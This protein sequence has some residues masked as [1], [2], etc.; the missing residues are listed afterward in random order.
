MFRVDPTCKSTSIVS[1]I[2]GSVEEDYP[3]LEIT[4]NHPI[5]ILRALQTDELDNT[6]RWRRYMF[7]D[8]WMALDIA[9]LD[10]WVGKSL[11][12]LL[13]EDFSSTNRM[14]SSLI[15]EIWECRRSGRGERR[16]EITTEDGVFSVN[17]SG[18]KLGKA[19]RIHKVWLAWAR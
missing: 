11:Y 13:P 8:L 18:T 16:F 2:R 1:H 3:F 9:L 19:K 6:D 7:D 10:T 17:A 14:T 12:V 5:W 4:R 15:T